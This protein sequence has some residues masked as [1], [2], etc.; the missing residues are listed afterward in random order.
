MG[1]VIGRDL[2]SPDLS[3]TSV[4]E[5]YEVHA[6]G[7]GSLLV[8]RCGALLAMR[9]ESESRRAELEEL[10]AH[11]VAPRLNQLRGAPSFHA[12]G[13]SLGASVVGF[14]GR[15][16]MGKS[17]LAASLANRWPVVSDDSLLVS[18]ES[19]R[20]I[21]KPSGRTSRL[22]D[23]TL[24]HMRLSGSEHR[25][26]GKHI[27]A[28]PTEGSEL[29]LSCLYVL[30]TS[31]IGA[32]TERF[33]QRDGLLALAEHLHRI[34]PFDSDLLAQEMSFLEAI[35]RRVP[36]R[37]LLYPRRFERIGEVAEAI[38]RDFEDDQRSGPSERL[39]E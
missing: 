29:P 1:D 32:T 15:S 24:A 27:V 26:Y 14:L 17:T 36:V 2:V 33:S 13:V 18:I 38:L 12:S 34:D 37:K 6:S 3:T 8:D 4:D 35:V 11:S 30:G 19:G 7:L 10:F 21:V 23:D 9:P 20:P 5:G 39:A 16:G 25:I 28:L 22:R 31:E